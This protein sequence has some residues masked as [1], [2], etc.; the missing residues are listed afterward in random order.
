MG[1]QT[2]TSLDSEDEHFTYE[3]S[4]IWRYNYGI[5]SGKLYIEGSYCKSSMGITY[6][7]VFN[8][9]K[10]IIQLQKN[11]IYKF[12]VTV[13]EKL[14]FWAHMLREAMQEPKI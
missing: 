3:M 8:I 4:F 9:Y 11:N 5:F 14:T 6:N 1:G 13:T 10:F 2:F 7:F 12:I